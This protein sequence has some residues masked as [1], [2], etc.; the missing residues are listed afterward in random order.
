MNNLVKAQIEK[1]FLSKSKSSIVW[2][3]NDLKKIN[4]DVK[5]ENFFCI[6]ELK[7]QCNIECIQIFTKNFIKTNINITIE[8]EIAKEQWEYIDAEIID[9]QK[10]D[11]GILFHIVKKNNIKKIRLMFNQK[12]KIVSIDIWQRK[13]NGLLIAA[14]NDAF[15]SRM[16]AFVTAIY[17]AKKTGMKFGFVWH[18]KE[19]EN[20]VFINSE[21]QMFEE[22]FNYE[23][24][25]TLKITKPKYNTLNFSSIK[26]LVDGNYE[27][28]WGQYV[29]NYYI[30]TN[31][32]IVDLDLED[33]KESFAQIFFTLPFNYKYKNILKS[34]YKKVDK[35]K[36]FIALHIRSGDLVYHLKY[37][38]KLYAP[39]LLKYLHPIEIAFYI[40]K[41]YIEKTNSDIVIFGSDYDVNLEIKKH[42]N[43]FYKD[44][45]KVS[46]D[47]YQ[48][49]DSGEQQL[50]DVVF[51]SY[52]KKIISNHSTYVK[53]SAYLKNS[54]YINFNKIFDSNDLYGAL[55]FYYDK[56]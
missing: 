33:F 39:F 6:I 47:F 2:K 54:E 15:G 38:N 1:S 56:I 52:A 7:N 48:E 23:H 17:L 45:C 42:L 5:W 43:S 21:F 12:I 40:G 26:E 53:F 4:Y 36:N 11:N 3:K 31:K 9:E 10:C 19:N 44:K 55:K 27:A 18:E 51:M 8:Y 35:I 34:V 30:P 22:Q 49:F 28:T 50:F 46:K 14:R 16:T 25:Y 20:G 13:Y 29:M 24:S 32:D 37:R 41:Y